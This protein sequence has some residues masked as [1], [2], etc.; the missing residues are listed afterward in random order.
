MNRFITK[1]KNDYSVNDYIKFI[2]NHDYLCV[3][4][5]GNRTNRELV[6]IYEDGYLVCC[7]YYENF[8]KIFYTEIEIRREKLKKLNYDNN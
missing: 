8:K 2:K 1:C 4:I 3:M 7:F 6:E 5:L